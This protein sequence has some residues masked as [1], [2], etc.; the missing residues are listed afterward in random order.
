MEI[1]YAKSKESYGTRG[2]DHNNIRYIDLLHSCD[3]TSRMLAYVKELLDPVDSVSKSGLSLPF[4]SRYAHTERVIC[5][6]LR[7]C[8]KESGDAGIIAVAAIFHDC[9]YS[10]GGENHASE[11]AR[12]FASYARQYLTARADWTGAET[13]NL[14]ADLAAAINAAVTSAESLDA[15]YNVIAVHSDKHLLDNALCTE[16]KILMDADLLDEE[17]AMA[18]VFDCFIE[19]DLP[20]F[21]YE[22]AFERISARYTAWADDINR[23]HTDEGMRRFIKMREYVGAFVSGLREELC[24]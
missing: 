18:V 16:A 9:G 8:E 7:I 14:R 6:A 15:I 17:G 10:N 2:G 23:F 21:D 19:A 24:R 11:S 20:V 22:S 12:L 3:L 1:N 4:R 5:Q 13:K